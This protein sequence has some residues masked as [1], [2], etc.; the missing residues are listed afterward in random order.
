M[1][2]IIKTSI[3][4]Y[5]SY[6]FRNLSNIV[7]KKRLIGLDK[8]PMTITHFA[9]LRIYD[10]ITSS[11]PIPLGIRVGVRRRGCNGLT[12]TMNYV[13]DNT[14]SKI[15]VAKDIIIKATNGVLIHIDPSA[16]FSIVGT[17][18]NWKDDGL[19]QEFTF[20]NPKS[21]GSCGCGESFNV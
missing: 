20:L 17:I 14:E 18:M 6:N 10:L 12:F 2:S 1:I 19:T 4:F 9:E 11:N 16:L 8:P 3:N 7:T 5:K 13:K 15:L 21:K